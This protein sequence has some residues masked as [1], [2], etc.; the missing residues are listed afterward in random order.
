MP[1]RSGAIVAGSPYRRTVPARPAAMPASTS[2]PWSFRLLLLF[3]L[4]LYANLPL[5]F[6]Q[7][8]WVAPAQTVAIA[9]F[10]VLFFEK[11]LKGRA[12]RLA[13]PE[14]WLL[15]AFVVCAALSTFGALWSRYA[16]EQ[17]LMLL[18]MVAV[19]L[20]ALNTIDD[21]RRLRVA[22]GTAVVGGLFPAVGALADYTQ[23]DWAAGE[24]AAWIG[25]FQNPNDLAYTLVLLL[26]LAL[27]LAP[28]ARGLAKP[29]YWGAAL[30]F[31][32]AIL[33]SFSRGG[34][35]GLWVVALA[36]FLR[37]GST[38]VRVIGAVVVSASLVFTSMLWTRNDT[39]GE[40]IDQATIA[41]RLTTIRA[42]AEMLADRPI[43]GVG[44][45]CSVIGWP[46]YAPPNTPSEIW[47]QTH[48]TLAQV[49]TETGVVGGV[50]FVLLLAAT[51]RG[52]F[53]ASR[54]LKQL[55]RGDLHRLVSAIEVSFYGF[56]VCGLTGGYLLSWFPWVLLGLA[57]A[58]RLLP[59]RRLAT[60]VV[61]TAR[62]TLAPRTARARGPAGLAGTPVR[63][64]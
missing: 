35:L 40:V 9:A 33:L 24:R 53:R 63:V 14:S 2:T 62:M 6:P 38:S 19:S 29:F 21:W 64:G 41:L 26:P 48:N 28:G 11:W 46:L 57:G 47:L 44:L 31:T 59:A 4:L 15:L 61:R 45:G 32:V 8:A 60:G 42:G 51:L 10:C 34:L 58:A 17:T 43:F 16:A 3:L 22:L 5:Q 18:K 20:L 39:G 55:R 12:I 23:R 25:T 54:R 27:G 30:V 1:A 37:W 50:V 49:F 13:R 56:L 7:L 36:C 52:T